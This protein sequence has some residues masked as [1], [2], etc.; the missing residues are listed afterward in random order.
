M[1]PDSRD[2]SRVQIVSG[3]SV[4]VIRASRRSKPAVRTARSTASRAAGSAK[5]RPVSSRR[6]VCTSCPN[7]SS[8]GS[9]PLAGSCRPCTRTR[10]ARVVDDRQRAPV[11]PVSPLGPLEP[12]EPLDRPTSQTELVQVPLHEVLHGVGG[13]ALRLR[14]VQHVTEALLDLRTRRVVAEV[15]AERLRLRGDRPVGGTTDR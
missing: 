9:C 4:E 1:R 15:T 2:L 12:L 8:P 7:G 5:H 11:L 6:S 14:T 13:A 3:S 10:G